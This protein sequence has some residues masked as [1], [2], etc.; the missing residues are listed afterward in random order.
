LNIQQKTIAENIIGKMKTSNNGLTSLAIIQTI[1]ADPNLRVSIIESLASDFNLIEKIGHDFRL[2]A[3]GHDFISFAELDKE[4]AEFKERE[5]IEFRKSK[6]DLE[7]AERVLKE[8]PRTKFFAWSGFIIGVL[9][10]LK[11]LYTML[12][13]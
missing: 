13:K 6:V 11:E 3:K 10:L 2:T 9:L 8:F 4:R 1:V 5:N 7:L 12:Y